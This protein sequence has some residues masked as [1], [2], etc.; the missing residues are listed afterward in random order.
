MMN[1]LVF[2]LYCLTFFFLLE[3]HCC[4]LI[5]RWTRQILHILC[6]IKNT[7]HALCSTHTFFLSS[8]MS[9][10]LPLDSNSKHIV[11]SKIFCNQWKWCYW[12]MI[13]FINFELNISDLSQ[14]NRI[15]WN[16]NRAS[17][18]SIA[19]SKNNSNIIK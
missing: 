18:I 14:S 1:F 13:N 12:K 6:A 19:C 9:W 3:K 11:Y 2:R 17:W 15:A 5:M 7:H 10:L 16:K 4:A 8:R